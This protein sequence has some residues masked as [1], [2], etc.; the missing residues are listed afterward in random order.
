[1]SAPGRHR[2]P[3]ARSG[4]AQR[5][6]PARLGAT[7]RARGT[8]TGHAA[9]VTHWRQDCPRMLDGS[10]SAS[11]WRKVSAQVPAPRSSSLL[12]HRVSARA[13]VPAIMAPAYASARLRRSSYRLFSWR[14]SGD[15]R[16]G[17]LWE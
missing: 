8:E 5:G 14:T 16:S 15:G 4:P 6:Q 3:V 13:E 11:R 17:G 9:V 7:H 12:P 10:M 1:M 2:S